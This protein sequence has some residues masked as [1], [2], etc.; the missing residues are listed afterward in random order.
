MTTDAHTLDARGLSCPLPILRTRKAIAE[1]ESGEVLEV[2][3]TDPGAIKDMDAFCRQTGHQLLS[4]LQV[5][6]TFVFQIRKS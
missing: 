6:D 5:K 3:A 1:L 4:S 2:S